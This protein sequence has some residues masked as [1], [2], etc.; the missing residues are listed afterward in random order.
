MHWMTEFPFYSLNLLF[1]AFLFDLI[2]SKCL[3]HLQ[4]FFGGEV[5]DPGAPN[6]RMFLNTPEVS[7]M[8]FS[9]L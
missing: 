8:V 7:Q 3:L 4:G 9:V 5:I 6:D 1:F 2:T